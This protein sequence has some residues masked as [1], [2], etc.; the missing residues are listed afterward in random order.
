MEALCS[1]VFGTAWEAGC[2]PGGHDLDQYDIND[3]FVIAM[4]TMPFAAARKAR[5]TS[6]VSTLTTRVNVVGTNISM[7]ELIKTICL[8]ETSHASVR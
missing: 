2:H 4:T 3:N 7:T 6:R 1:V 8:D 5:N